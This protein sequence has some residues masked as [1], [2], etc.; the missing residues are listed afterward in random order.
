MN[1]LDQKIEEK[2]KFLEEYDK[3][4][5]TL[6]IQKPKIHNNNIPLKKPEEIKNNNS[7]FENI[8]SNFEFERKKSNADWNNVEDAMDYKYGNNQNNKKKINGDKKTEQNS[9]DKK[10]MPNNKNNNNKIKTKNQR[11]NKHMQKIENKK[12]FEIDELPDNLVDRLIR[13]GEILRKKKEMLLQQNEQE[14]K[15]MANSLLVSQNNK[16]NNLDPGRISERL[17]NNKYKKENDKKEKKEKEHSVNHNLTFRPKINKKSLEIANKLEPSSSR[18]LKK[19]KTLDKKDIKKLA[20]DNYRNLFLN[21]PYNNR[22]KKK[23]CNINTNRTINRLYNI[24]LENIKKKELKYKENFIKKSEDYKNYSFHPQTITKIVKSTSLKQIN[25][26]LY[27]KPFEQR[28]QKILENSKKKEIKEKAY[29]NECT[30]K[31]NV[32]AEIKKDEE[33]FIKQYW[34]NTN[35]YIEKKKKKI[36][37]N[38]EKTNQSY[39]VS[40]KNYGFSLKDLYYE[41]MHS[42]NNGEVTK[43]ESPYLNLKKVYNTKRNCRNYKNSLDCIIPPHTKRIFCYYNENGDINN[44]IKTNNFNN[45]DY[46]K[47]GFIDAINALHKEIGNL[48]I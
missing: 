40:K 17:Y 2:L 23:K 42:L 5:K 4:I 35:N 32:S 47:Y 37:E 22:N 10:S 38:N 46:S 18:L 25:E 24:G 7:L 33:K 45:V 6:D 16:N 19:K 14:F 11:S 21:N 43:K 29:F 41:P 15:N 31:P 39:N 26:N 48:N 28:S 30:F 3:N 34:K 44:S 27:Q 1:L 36:K 12:K 20:V 8:Y 13:Q 9:K